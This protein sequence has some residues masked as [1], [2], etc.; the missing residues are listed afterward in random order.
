MKLLQAKNRQ[1]VAKTERVTR[2][3]EAEA[4]AAYMQIIGKFL[5]PVYLER[6]RVQALQDLYKRVGK[7]DKVILSGEGSAFPIVGK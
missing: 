7:G 3:M 2:T 1:A 6:L 5:T 4:E